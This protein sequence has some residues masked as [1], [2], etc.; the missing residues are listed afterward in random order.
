M[1]L[2][3]TPPPV[4]YKISVKDFKAKFTGAEMRAIDQAALTDDAL[5]RYEKLLNSVQEVDLTNIE[6]REGIAH[7]VS[8]GIL[9]EPKASYVLDVNTPPRPPVEEV[10]EAVDAEAGE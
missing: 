5:Y 3:T 6:T 9:D 1:I 7:L 8:L 4:S 10:E 2:H